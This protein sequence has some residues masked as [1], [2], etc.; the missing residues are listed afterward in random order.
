MANSV[1]G[2]NGEAQTTQGGNPQPATVTTGPDRATTAPQ[3]AAESSQTPVSTPANS[4]PSAEQS[5]GA[6]TTSDPAATN[7][8]ASQQQPGAASNAAS[9]V[10]SPQAAVPQVAI[11]NGLLPTAAAAVAADANIAQ[12]A[13]ATGN[14]PEAQVA[15]KLQE[16]A[17]FLETSDGQDGDG[18]PVPARLWTSLSDQAVAKLASWAAAIADNPEPPAAVQ[19]AAQ[20]VTAAEDG[21]D[22]QQTGGIA[23]AKT[24]APAAA[25]QPISSAAVPASEAADPVD[26]LRTGSIP[27]APRE[28]VEQSLAAAS[29]TVQAPAREAPPWPYVAAYPPG[30][31]EPRRQGRKTPPVLAIEDEE[32]DG[33]SEQYGAE[34]EQDEGEEPQDEAED[35][36][37]ASDTMTA[38]EKAAG[39]IAS[40]ASVDGGIAETRPS[41]LYWHMAGWN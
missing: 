33:S 36:A 13:I 11:A 19:A 28:T 39:Y 24:A 7:A 4:N 14:E 32:P 3:K 31:D 40:D 23:Q 26:T 37:V 38:A 18:M 34:D 22:P 15:A 16:A 1:T 2:K 5:S 8:K 35:E 6:D 30:E 41:D 9:Q 29:A 20:V 10:G 17:A 25:Q 21:V 12:Q 27:A